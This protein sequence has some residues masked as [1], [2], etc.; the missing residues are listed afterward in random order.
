MDQALEVHPEHSIDEGE[1]HPFVDEAIVGQA[2]TKTDGAEDLNAPLFEDS[3]PNAG[4]DVVPAAQL[5]D[6]ALDSVGG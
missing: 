3:G 2:I 6:H 5:Q 1:I 4:Q